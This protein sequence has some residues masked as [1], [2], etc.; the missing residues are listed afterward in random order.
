MRRK[1]AMAFKDEN[2]DNPDEDYEIER[3]ESLFE[4]GEE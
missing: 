1:D 3:D 4:N 2:Y